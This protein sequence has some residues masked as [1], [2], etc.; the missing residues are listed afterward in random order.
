VATGYES[1]LDHD[2][3]EAIIPVTSV[4]EFT[5]LEELVINQALL[6]CK[7]DSSVGTGRL[8]RL[9]PFSIQKVHFTYVYKSMYE[10]LMYLAWTAPEYFP[11]FRSVKIGLVSPIPLE[12]VAEIAHMKTVESAFAIVGAHVSW[13]E[14][15]MGPYLYTAIPGGTPGLTVTCVPAAPLPFP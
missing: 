6:Y 9:L 5:Q 10:D 2:Y 1:I 12:R 13:E 3:Y 15:F 7:S 4:R 8:E 11:N 14:N